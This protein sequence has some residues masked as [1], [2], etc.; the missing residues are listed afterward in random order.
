MSA[1]QEYLG[2]AYLDFSKKCIK[3]E[4]TFSLDVYLILTEDVIAKKQK[5][6]L[7]QL[8]FLVTRY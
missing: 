7:G 5:I 4:V 3:M 6:T 2:E 8:I 1:E